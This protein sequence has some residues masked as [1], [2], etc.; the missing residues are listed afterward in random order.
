[1]WQLF[2]ARAETRCNFHAAQNKMKLNILSIFINVT[3]KCLTP[4]REGTYIGTAHRRTGLL[5]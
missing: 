4:V 1:M 2:V 5:P 3:W